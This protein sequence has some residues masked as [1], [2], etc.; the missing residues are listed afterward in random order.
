MRFSRWSETF[1]DQISDNKVRKDHKMMAQELKHLTF[2]RDVFNPEIIVD[3]ANTDV[4]P[5]GQ[6]CVSFIDRH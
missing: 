2:G 3:I 1:N 5:A 4:I 6:K